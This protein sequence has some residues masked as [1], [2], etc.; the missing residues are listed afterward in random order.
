[1]DGKTGRQ[2]RL[3]WG[4]H[5]R[6]I[7]CLIMQQADIARLVRL[8]TYLLVKDGAE[9]CNSIGPSSVEVGCRRDTGLNRD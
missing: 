3:W 4:N 8:P 2:G 6:D 5:V 1:M 7:S 9:I